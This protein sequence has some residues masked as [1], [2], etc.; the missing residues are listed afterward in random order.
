[1]PLTEKQREFIARANHRWN[2]KVGA[3]RSGKTYGDYFLIPHR[4]RDPART[5]SGGIVLLVGATTATVARNILDP[6]R[7]IWGEALVGRPSSDGGSVTMFGEKCVI[8][9]ASN[10][11]QVAKIQGASVKYCYG[12]EVTTWSPDLFSML[13]SRLDRPCS[14]FDGTCNPAG[15]RH[16]FKK[17]LDSGGD[18]YCQ[19]YTIDDNPM[20]P[21]EFVRALKEEYAG[22]VWYDRYILGRWVAAEGA[23][24]RRFADS[25][26]DYTL[27]AG[28]DPSAVSRIAVGVDFG[29]NRSATAF[30]AVGEEI[31]EPYLP[32]GAEKA[33]SGGRR[34]LVLASERHSGELDSGELSARFC[35]FCARLEHYGCEITAYCDNAEPVLMRSLK[36]AAREAAPFVSVRPALKLPVTDRIRFTLRLLASGR[37]MLTEH[38]DTVSEAL[39]D[40]RWSDKTDA[41]RDVRLDDGSSDI[42]TLDALEYAIEREMSRYV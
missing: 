37:L 39:C 14:V 15:P 12:D 2:V 29:G 5:S 28:Y 4:I 23:I 32:D 25:P 7:K 11:G 33:N 24:Y 8:V 19:T 20:L 22:T 38:A 17:F 1:M 10:S 42:D 16:W 9:G 27:P 35:E 3:V 34:L 40:A 21:P 13:Q 18:I 26:G 31:L 30:V 6:M 41:G 36:A